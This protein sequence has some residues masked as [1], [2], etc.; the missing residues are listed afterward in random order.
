MR[1]LQPPRAEILP[2]FERLKPAYQTY[3]QGVSVRSMALSIETCAYV[4]WL[5]DTVRARR[6]ADLGSG[7]SSYVLRAYAADAAYQPVQVDSVDSDRGWLTATRD[8][9]RTQDQ[10]DGGFMLGP[11]WAGSDTHYDVV[12]NDYDSGPTREAFADLAAQKLTAAGVV[13]FDDA[14]NADHHHNMAEVCIHHGLTLLD[15]Y[16]QTVDELGRFAMAAAR[17]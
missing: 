5:C 6:V 17:L 2:Y 9:C 15:L 10:P 16:H 8:F 1:A 7:F 13:V 12:V 14:Q 3:C 4:W 11:K